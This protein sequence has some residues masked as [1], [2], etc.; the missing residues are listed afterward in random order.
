MILIPVV[1]QGLCNH[2]GPLSLES[3]LRWG[4]VPEPGM[5]ALLVAIGP[6]GLKLLSGI[7]HGQ[8]P[9]SIQTFLARAGVKGL[10]KGT[11]RRLARSGEVQPNLVQV[12]PLVQQTFGTLGAVVAENPLRF[13]ALRT[14]RSSTSPT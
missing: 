9:G 4:Q 14:I 2:S 5:G 13:A 1:V 7:A 6:P 3:K 12:R 11:V 10:N 8:K